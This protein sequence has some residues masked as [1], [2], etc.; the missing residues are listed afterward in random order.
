[1]VSIFLIWPTSLF[2]LP[3][4]PPL[5]P[6]LTSHLRPPARCSTLRTSQLEVGE[7]PCLP[8]AAQQSTRPVLG[9]WCLVLYPAHWTVII[10][11]LSSPGP[12]TTAS[13]PFLLP[14]PLWGQT[15][16][17]FGVAVASFRPGMAI[18]HQQAAISIG[19]WRCFCCSS[20]SYFPSRAVTPCLYGPN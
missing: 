20:A 18:L 13:F 16:P 3:A 14:S 5:L 8:F 4:A 6:P 10:S 1:M 9:T 11:S 7:A 15:G 17:A 12:Y 2:P 19:H